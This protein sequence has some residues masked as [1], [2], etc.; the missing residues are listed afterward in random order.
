ME[1]KKKLEELKSN[2][3]TINQ[4]FEKIDGVFSVD[5]YKK[6]LNNIIKSIDN[7]DDSKLEVGSTTITDYYDETSRMINEINEEYF[8]F[9]EMYLLVNYLKSIIDKVNENNCEEFYSHIINLVD[10][11]KR[12]STSTREDCNKVIDEA[13]ELIYKGI[14]YER[15]FGSSRLFTYFIN[16]C[17]S[18]ME[19]KISSLMKNDINSGLSKEDILKMELNNLDQG[20]DFNYLTG[21]CV[22][23]T[24]KS[25]YDEGYQAFED[26]KKTATMELL[27]NFDK[28]QEEK[29]ELKEK[30]EN[31]R[32][33]VREIKKDLAINHLK[34]LALAM[35]PIA[36]IFG[37]TQIDIKTYNVNKIT[38]NLSTN[39]IIEETQV[40]NETITQYEAVIKKIGPWKFNEKHGEYERELLEYAVF[41]TTSDEIPTP[42]EI[43]TILDKPTRKVE[44]KKEL[45]DEEK[46]MEEQIIISETIRDNNSAR[47]SWAI[48]VGLIVMFLI[49]FAATDAI[50]YTET[51]EEYFHKLLEYIE[52][53]I[54]GYKDY[55]NENGIVQRRII[56]ERTEEI[57]DKVVRFQEEVYNKKAKYKDILTTIEPE[58][59][60]EIKRYIKR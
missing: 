41:E 49:I 28:I 4:M 10:C 48:V 42:E 33:K 53:I 44:R 52:N 26:R 58:T 36:S 13:F 47:K 6:Q 25:I 31:R 7:L 12:N 57:G 18:Y 14:I 35:I 37:L 23:E 22:E 2:I 19:A 51:G 56:K 3:I 45:T 60:E 1:D 55:F 46:Q 43:M 24:S 21:E 29:K 40:S 34:F 32:Y 27:S 54:E 16:N 5:N 50:V 15:S 9:Y 20:I 8:P 30:K 11:V 59:L 38:R 39:E 17:N